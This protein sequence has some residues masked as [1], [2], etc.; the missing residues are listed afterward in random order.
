MFLVPSYVSKTPLHQDCQANPINRPLT[1]SLSW[2]T[3]GPPTWYVPFFPSLSFNPAN[4]LQHHYCKPSAKS[5]EDRRAL[6][7][8]VVTSNGN[9]FLGTD[10]A[11]TRLFPAPPL[12]GLD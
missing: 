6:L 7:N 9:F 10:S 4:K 11:R 8:A 1:I 2:S 5:P 12:Y 3:T